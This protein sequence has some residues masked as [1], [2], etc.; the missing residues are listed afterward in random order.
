MVKDQADGLLNQVISEIKHLKSQNK[1][2]KYESNADQKQISLEQLHTIIKASGWAC[3]SPSP[4]TNPRKRAKGCSLKPQRRQGGQSS[5][6]NTPWENIRS[7]KN[8][9]N[10]CQG[11]SKEFTC[12]TWSH[13]SLSAQHFQGPSD[14]GLDK[15]A[16]N[17][18]CFEPSPSGSH[19]TIALGWQW[20]LLAWFSKCHHRSQ[21][22]FDSR[23]LKI[24]CYQVHW[25]PTRFSQKSL[26]PALPG[27]GKRFFWPSSLDWPVHCHFNQTREARISPRVPS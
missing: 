6:T 3:W 9:S 21:N 25:P 5:P 15:I 19:D 20:F 26:S 18:P 2:L 17:I 8:G 4:N 23:D 24:Q 1:L 7:R 27:V 16:H 10:Q 12:A 13:P 11:S 22:I 14:R